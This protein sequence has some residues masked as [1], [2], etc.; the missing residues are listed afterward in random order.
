MRSSR[1][2]VSRFLSITS[3]L[4]LAACPSED[5]CGPGDAPAEIAATGLGVELTF[6]GMISGANNDCPIDGT[7]DGVVSMSIQGTQVGNSIGFFTLCVPRP[8]QLTA[9]E[10]LGIDDPASDEPP[11][12]IVDISGSDL[13]CSYNYDNTPPTGT[14]RAE[15]LCD[16]SGLGE[17]GFALVLDGQVT[18]SR[19]CGGVEDTGVV[20]ISGSVAVQPDPNQ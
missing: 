10:D 5:D 7:P 11:V 9:G 8:D 6:G 17:G 2:S 19:D 4:L 3:L 13:G 18:L 16:T 14:A 12:R 20:T 1:T 15:G